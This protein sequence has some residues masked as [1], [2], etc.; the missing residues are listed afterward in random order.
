MF[1]QVN[2][3]NNKELES[4]IKQ[5]EKRVKELVLGFCFWVYFFGNYGEF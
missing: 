1:E 2:Y 5:L 3:L 4:K